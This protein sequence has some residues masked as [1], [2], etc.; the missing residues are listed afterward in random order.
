[1]VK[2]IQAVNDVE[3]QFRNSP[4]TQNISSPPSKPGHEARKTH[5]DHMADIEGGGT[6][7]NIGQNG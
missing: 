7:E 4:V 1:V 3:K 5:Q 6:V 2:P